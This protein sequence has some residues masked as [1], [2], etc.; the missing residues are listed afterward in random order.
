MYLCLIAPQRMCDW[1]KE[2]ECD[3]VVVKETARYIYVYVYMHT[4]YMLLLPVVYAE[5]FCVCTLCVN[6]RSQYKY[7]ASYCLC[8]ASDD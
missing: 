5:L 6:T 8:F 3:V 7:T 2:G 1:L 4:K